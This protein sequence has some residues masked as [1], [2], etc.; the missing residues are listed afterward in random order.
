[1]C[2]F[3]APLGL[4]TLADTELRQAWRE[5]DPQRP[6]HLLRLVHRME[7]V[8]GCFDI[9][10]E[11]AYNEGDA[12]DDGLLCLLLCEQAEPE[13]W[14]WGGDAILWPYSAPGTKSRT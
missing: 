3:E 10:P 2:D 5:L 11:P 4:A 13:L 1:M 6:M 8:G 12:G 7:G 9:L 14:D